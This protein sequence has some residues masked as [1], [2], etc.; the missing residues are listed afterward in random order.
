MI[1]I[2]WLT[3]VIFV[4]KSYLVAE[5][6]QYSM[7]V[8]QFR[9]DLKDIEDG[10][11]ITFED[12]HRHNTQVVLAGVTYSRSVE[13]INGY[14]VE[15]EDD[16]TANGEYTVRLYGANHNIS[17][18]KV[19]NSVSIVVQNSAGLIQVSSGSGL[20][21]EQATQLEELWKIHGLKSGSPLTVSD[22]ARAAG[23]VTQTIADDGSTT[24]VT[25]T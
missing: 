1:S 8:N 19:A 2:D 4:P 3:K 16:G 5:G 17:D 9:L 6:D 7:D 25:R 12:T 22:S 21:A 20:S 24:T 11:G 15:F 14:T 18:V 10:D 13:I 23:G